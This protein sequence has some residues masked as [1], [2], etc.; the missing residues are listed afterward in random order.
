MRPA[1]ASGTTTTSGRGFLSVVVVAMVS[2]LGSCAGVEDEGS[3]EEPEFFYPDEWKVTLREATQRAEFDV[4]VPDHPYASRRTLQDVYLK[5]SR[6]T[7]I[8]TFPLPRPPEAPLRQDHLEIFEEPWE[9]GDPLADYEK[10][11]EF[12]PVTGKR[13]HWI[14]GVPALGLEAHAPEDETGENPALLRFVIDGVEVQ[15][16]GGESVEDLIAIARTIIRYGGA[17]DGG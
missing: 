16:S 8:L 12:A 6:L 1:R 14:D 7:V 11:I 5:P 15:I 13:I 10:S 17:E 9:S 4:K 3:P 2:L